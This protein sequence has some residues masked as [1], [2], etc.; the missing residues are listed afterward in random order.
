M[1]NFF[2]KIGNF[3]VKVGSF[4]KK[5]FTP[6]GHFLNKYVWHYLR[7]LFVPIAKFFSWLFHFK[8]A[9][10]VTSSIVC[11]FIGLFAGFIIMLI[12]DPENCFAGIAVLF[13]AGFQGMSEGDFDA[14]SHVIG[15]MTPMVMAGI[16]I[17]F[18]FKLGLFNIGITGQLTMG[19]FIAL[20]CS[21]CGM[22]W[23][24]CI[25][26]A[27]A[28]GAFIGMISGLLKAHFNVNEV[29]SGIMLN[30][31]VYYMCGLLGDYLPSDWIDKSNKT[32]LAKMFAAGRLPTLFNEFDAE[33]FVNQPY[34]NITAGIFISIGVA[35]IIWFVLKFTRFGFEL[36]LCGSNKFAAKYAGI[37]QNSKIVLSL[38]ISGAIA[39]ACGYMVFA[40][41]SPKAFTFGALDG[42]MLSDGFNGISVALIGQTDPI[43][44]IFSSFILAYLSEGQT[45]IVN[46]SILYSKY[47]MELIKAVIIYA[48]SFSAFI[49]ILIRKA[50]EE[51]KVLIDTSFNE[52]YRSKK[53]ESL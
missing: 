3:F 41:P 43:G 13:T 52:L 26:A 37:N 6:V 4:F 11:I 9:R 23:H 27:I 21:F 32:Q 22:P 5:A 49:G 45:Q 33:G 31:I 44:C 28:G 19:A 12:R 39:G 34:Y 17:S 50:N 10:A 36:K 15:T 14:I 29:L 40:T 2:S 24:V 18:A 35:I 20:V 47:Y 16:S 30:W 51:N 1:K 25:L 42:V 8:V 48:A 46:V 38:L 7:Y 53:E